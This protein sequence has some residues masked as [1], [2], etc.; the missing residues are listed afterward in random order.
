M[1]IPSCLRLRVRDPSQEIRGLR[2]KAYLRQTVAAPPPPAGRSLSR[3]AQRPLSCPLLRK[4]PSDLITSNYC[5]DCCLG[6]GSNRSAAVRSPKQ[7]NLSWLDT[8]SDAQAAHPRSRGQHACRGVAAATESS[9][10][11]ALAVAQGQV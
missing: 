8:V 6:L 11:L 5:P 10:M 4:W 7:V 1:F 3:R 9:V 2:M